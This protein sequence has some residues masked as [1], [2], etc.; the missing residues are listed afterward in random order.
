MQLVFATGAV[1]IP[2]LLDR[3]GMDTLTAMI[4]SFAAL[5]RNLPVMVLWGVTIVVLVA[6]GVLTSYLGLIVV[7]PL[8][9]HASWHA[10]RDCV[11]PVPSPP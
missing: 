2:M 8:V 3:H 4:T 11:E 1:S 10:Y 5:R 7:V 9:G 6:A